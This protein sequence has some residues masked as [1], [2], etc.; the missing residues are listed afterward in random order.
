M[1]FNKQNF[2]QDCKKAAIVIAHPDDETIWMG[3][4][5]LRFNN[6]EWKI[7]VLTACEGE[8]VKNLKEAIE[9]YKEFGV[10][11]LSYEC[12]PIMKNEQ[13]IE[14][15]DSVKIENDLDL[16]SLDLSSYDYIF[17]HNI[18]GEY[19]H[20]N[21]LVIGEYFKKSSLKNVWHFLCPAIQ[22]PREK[23][24]GLYIESVYLNNVIRN[25]KYIIFHDVYKSEQYLFS[26]CN[27]FMNFEF[28]SG[29]EMFTKY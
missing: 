12:V 25:R 2:L 9:K 7:F 5:I 23:Q 22:N 16:S 8:R 19:H 15:L 24:I 20:C 17:T 10:K 6:I 4:T 13:L 29:I 11:K 1:N 27:D 21:H 28:C 26:A 14:K 3:G 18:D